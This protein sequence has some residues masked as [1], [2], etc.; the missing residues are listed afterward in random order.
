[1]F[2]GCGAYRP[3]SPACAVAANGSK[4][5]MAHEV[6]HVLGLSHDSTNGNLMHPT[7]A[8]YPKLLALTAGQVTTVRNSPLCR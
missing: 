3:G 8:S 4:Y 1:M 7:Q 2:L 6:G 5:D